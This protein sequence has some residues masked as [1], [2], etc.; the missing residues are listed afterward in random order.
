MTV[1]PARKH[2]SLSSLYCLCLRLC[3]CVVL[4]VTCESHPHADNVTPRCKKNAQIYISNK[5]NDKNNTNA[6]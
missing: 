1:F 6:Q 3:R 5:E 2:T 4:H